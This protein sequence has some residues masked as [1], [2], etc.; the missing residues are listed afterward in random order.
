MMSHKSTVLVLHDLP[1][2]FCF[3]T[4]NPKR[5]F[6]WKIL[7]IDVVVVRYSRSKSCA[8]RAF[9]LLVLY[10]VSYRVQILTDTVCECKWQMTTDHG[11]RKL[12]SLNLLAVSEFDTYYN[13]N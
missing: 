2:F 12:G 5:K 3:A 6:Q 13:T 1:L 11:N 10:R 8:I 7:S 9:L 4:K